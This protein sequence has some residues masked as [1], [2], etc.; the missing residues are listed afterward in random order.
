M[1]P[2]SWTDLDQELHLSFQRIIEPFPVHQAI[3]L[4]TDESLED[5]LAKL[6]AQVVVHKPPCMRSSISMLLSVR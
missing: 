4:A 5:V 2:P 1:F 3:K 6:D